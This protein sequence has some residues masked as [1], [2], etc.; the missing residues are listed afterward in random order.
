VGARVTSRREFLERS[1]LAAIATSLSARWGGDLRDAAHA[2]PA[3][4][5]FLDLLREPDAVLV[6]SASGDRRLRRETIGRWTSNAIA[7]TTD[8]RRDALNV[9]LS[10]PG[11]AVSRVHLRWRGRMTDARL[12]LGDAWE[13]CY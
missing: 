2:G 8:G 5:G 11:V 6:Q 4:R 12:I 13:R 10:S 7:V 1:T 3:P 9:G